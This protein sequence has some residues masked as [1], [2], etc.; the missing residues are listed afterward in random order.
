[1]TARRHWIIPEAYR[2]TGD[3]ARF[4]VLGEITI[5]QT[6]T[7]MS[8]RL[9]GDETG[10]L[11]SRADLELMIA[12]LRVA[13]E[14]AADDISQ[15]IAMLNAMLDGDEDVVEA[16]LIATWASGIGIEQ[17]CTVDMATG[18][19]LSIQQ[20][21]LRSP[22]DLNNQVVEIGDSTY[23]IEERDHRLFIVLGAPIDEEED[24]SDT[25]DENTSTAG[26]SHPV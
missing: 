12:K 18:E 23:P 26:D 1:M 4:T 22:G 3:S 9:P 15:K 21:T 8:T 19:I 11:Y 10:P 14:T 6:L 24:V 17:Q 25:A 5:G 7:G 2:K 20:I 16:I 13:E